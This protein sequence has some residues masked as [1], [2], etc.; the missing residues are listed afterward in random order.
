M[1]F[2]I[3]SP[4]S[5]SPP[6][7]LVSASVVRE[8][9]VDYM[10]SLSET[11]QFVESHQPAKLPDSSTPEEEDSPTVTVRLDS[12]DVQDARTIDRFE[13]SADVDS[14]TVEYKVDFEE[15]LPDPRPVRA[16]FHQ[17]YL[18]LATMIKN[19]RRWLREWLEFNLMNGVD[20]FIIYDNESTD[21]PVEILQPYIDQ[22]LITYLNWPPKEIPPPKKFRTVL[23]RWQYRW[24]RDALLTCWD[25]DWVLHKQGPCQLAAFMDAIQRTN[26]GV[27]RWLGIWDVDEF[28]FPKQQS[29]FRTLSG[30]LRWYFPDSDH[31][32]IWG[33]V[34]GT[35]GH[36]EHAA[37]RKPGSPLPALLTEEYTWRSVLHRMTLYRIQ[38][39][40]R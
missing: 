16:K 40:I 24:L 33:N 11:Y 12:M 30:V 29:N 23:E 31:I 25:N 37:E 9:V 18:T 21:M 7:T 6:T 19:Q 39:N 14:A 32:K 26:N 36:I 2:F 22:G 4:P 20:H 3:Q 35:N 8:D 10:S 5:T 13:D 27:S 15:Y 28:I 34:F 17:R 1:V 38:I